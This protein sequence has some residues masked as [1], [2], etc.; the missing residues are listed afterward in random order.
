M[1]CGAYRL[2]G[3]GNEFKQAKAREVYQAMIDAALSE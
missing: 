3:I 2:P 1:D